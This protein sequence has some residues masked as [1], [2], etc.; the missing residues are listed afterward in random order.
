MCSKNIYKT[1]SFH[2]IQEAILESE[3]AA[4]EAHD[5]EFLFCIPRATPIKK[6]ITFVL[7]LLLQRRYIRN[8]IPSAIAAAPAITTSEPVPFLIHSESLSSLR[9]RLV[10]N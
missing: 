8:R 4:A 7:Q 10:F 6:F 1:K 9:I 2:Y 3:E 5:I